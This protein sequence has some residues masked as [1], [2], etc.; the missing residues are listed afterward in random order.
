[1]TLNRELLEAALRGYEAQ[2]SEIEA[3]IAEVLDQLESPV[4]T[5]KRVTRKIERFGR[6]IQNINCNA[7]QEPGKR[8]KRKM[9]AEVRAKIAAASKK[10]WAAYRKAKKVEA[11]EVA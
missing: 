1:M 7:P 6:R 8:K 10:R 3:H 4:E 2:K 11:A 5:M 9:S